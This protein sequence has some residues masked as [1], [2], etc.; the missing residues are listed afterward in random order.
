MTK[1]PLNATD[2]LVQLVERTDDDRY[3]PIGSG[4]I[5]G[6]SSIA[7]VRHVIENLNGDLLDENRI[8]AVFQQA[9]HDPRYIEIQHISADG[10]EHDAAILLTVSYYFDAENIA[11]VRPALSSYGDDVVFCGF[12]NKASRGQCFIG[13]GAL[14]HGGSIVPGSILRWVQ[15]NTDQTFKGMSGGPVFNKSTGDMVALITERG[16]VGDVRDNEEL[17][18]LAIDAASLFLK[19]IDLPYRERDDGEEGAARPVFTQ[20]LSVSD[21]ICRPEDQISQTGDA[22]QFVGRVELRKT[23]TEFWQNKRLGSESVFRLHGLPGIGKT[24]LLEWFHTSLQIGNIE[25]KPEFSIYYDFDSDPTIE[26]FVEHLQLHAPTALQGLTFSEIV[27]QLE[28]VLVEAHGLLILDGLE[29]MQQKP[30]EGDVGAVIDP[31]LRRLIEIFELSNSSKLVLAS[32]LQIALSRNL[33]KRTNGQK[34]EALNPEAAKELHEILL[35]KPG[36]NVWDRLCE[37]LA[38]HPGALKAVLFHAKNTGLHDLNWALNIVQGAE[39][40]GGYSAILNEIYAVLSPE[41]RA[42]MMTVSQLDGE[43][44]MTQLSDVLKESSLPNLPGSFFGVSENQIK[45][46]VDHLEAYSLISV[47]SGNAIGAHNLVKDY[48]SAHFAQ[49][50]ELQRKNI[51]LRISKSFADRFNPGTTPTDI[52]MLRPGFDAVE[53]LCRAG[54]FGDAVDFLTTRI[55]GQGREYIASNRL[56]GVTD[57]AATLRHFFPDG[58]TTLEP[59]ISAG[60]QRDTVLHYMGYC[61]SVQGGYPE[62]ALQMLSQAARDFARRGI[63]DSALDVYRA[64]S[65]SAVSSG[66]LLTAGELLAEALGISRESDNL[67][68]EVKVLVQ[69]VVTS[70]MT[71]GGD[72]RQPYSIV[73]KKL[74]KMNRTQRAKFL[75]RNSQ[76]VAFLTRIGRVRE[77]NRLQSEV[78]RPYARE[79]GWTDI[80]WRYLSLQA[81]IASSRNSRMAGFQTAMNTISSHHRDDLKAEVANRCARYL[82]GQGLSEE[83]LR[84]L[85]EWTQELPLD[86]YPLIELDIEVTKQ[87]AMVAGC[88]ED[89]IG[90]GWETLTERAQGLSYSWA[91]QDIAAYK[92]DPDCSLI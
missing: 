20:E 80:E 49:L 92:D 90:S 8:F 24:A 36:T 54:E 72:W 2:Y 82:I 47:T 56:G 32:R 35:G 83:A 37:R 84:N 13:E 38:N 50:S 60:P 76:F 7:S 22:E 21:F 88:T 11:F 86:K 78:L 10:G 44:D 23:L 34:L 66:Q 63:N 91:L 33:L 39:A 17:Y 3:E 27:N 79:N 1:L 70:H 28:S 62:R 45:E 46:V 89:G 51:H 4:V 61:E 73:R 31:E 58:D 81:T 75:A 43:I 5:V 26:G 87:A 71:I 30:T 16:G 69:S 40:D 14:A 74:S 65:Y 6:D 85:E 9:G 59:L 25:P 64:A 19:K 52:A 77:A 29:N 53:H 68:E 12:P 67:T 57:L 18:G 15:I 55:Q 48:F 42:V 41:M